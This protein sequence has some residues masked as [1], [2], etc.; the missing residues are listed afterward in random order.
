MSAHQMQDI[1]PYLEQLQAVLFRCRT[2]VSLK[3]PK[4]IIKAFIQG[5]KPVALQNTLFDEFNLNL[6]P[7]LETL[8]FRTL[9]LHSNLTSLS[10]TPQNF[11]P[12]DGSIPSLPRNE[13]R[14]SSNSDNR[15]N[16][17]NSSH[18]LSN[19]QCNFCKK[20]GHSI[21][22][23]PDPSCRTSKLNKRK[24][25]LYTNPRNPRNTADNSKRSTRL[26][27]RNNFT[28]GK[29]S[30]STNLVTSND[31]VEEE[32]LEFD[33]ELPNFLDNAYTS[34]PTSE[35][36]TSK[37]CLVKS[38]AE[39]LQLKT[40]P[41][42]KALSPHIHPL[43]LGGVGSSVVSAL[44]A[45]DADCFGRPEAP[46]LIEADAEDEAMMT[47]KVN[48]VPLTGTWDSACE[49]SC[50]SIDLAKKANLTLEESPL[51]FT[52][53][54]GETV[55]SPGTAYTKVSFQFGT[56]VPK[57]VLL[58][59]SLHVIPGSNQFL[60]GCDVMKALGL[61]KDN[62]LIINLNEKALPCSTLNHAWTLS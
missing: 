54:N 24:S 51:T 26:T 42:R 13:S 36:P 45:D 38:D 61:L 59:Y 14:L 12:K 44:V 20:S 56:D 48:S 31:T 17:P 35:K 62:N 10:I 43:T 27:S 50:L 8:L 57:I 7:S 49:H 15:R 25:Y 55:E 1:F 19:S 6:L 5:I 30:C 40:Q 32:T 2:F 52:L 46:Q 9:A 37:T 60:L 33:I 4:P 3:N 22:Q 28:S 34:S 23:C 11:T 29:K 39:P 53:A 47:V 16:H 21:D 58:Q 41:R 18:T